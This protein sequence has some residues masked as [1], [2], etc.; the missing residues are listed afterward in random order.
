MLK[1]DEIENPESCI[2]RAAPNEPVFVLRAIDEAAPHVIEVWAR[3]R[4]ILGKNKSSDQ[5]IIGALET[6]IRMREW[7]AKECLMQN[8]SFVSAKPDIK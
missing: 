4:V 1:K 3:E 8:A 7:R 6:A 2:N 5:K